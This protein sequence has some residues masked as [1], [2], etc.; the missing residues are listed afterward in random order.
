MIKSIIGHFRENRKIALSLLLLLLLSCGLGDTASENK[1]LTVKNNQLYF[2]SKT[3]N[4]VLSFQQGSFIEKDTIFINKILT[5]KG[6]YENVGNVID[7]KT[8]KPL[9]D[10][11]DVR[12]KVDNEYYLKEDAEDYYFIDKNYIYIYKDDLIARKIDFYIGGKS[13]DYE[14]LGGSYLRVGEKV[15]CKGTLLEGVDLRTFKTYK[16]PMKN[17]EWYKTIA[18]DKNKLYIENLILDKDDY[19]KYEDK[20]IHVF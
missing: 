12:K 18:A 16:L 1:Y 20:I 8:F 11:K 2:R 9:Y 6:Q 4:N 14:V 3:L 5:E 17:S 19:K 13:S 15:F 7:P 10:D